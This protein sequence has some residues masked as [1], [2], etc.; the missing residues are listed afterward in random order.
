MSRVTF[1]C[2]P[3]AS[4]LWML[5]LE[6]A[7]VSPA[8]SECSPLVPAWRLPASKS[9]ASKSLVISQLSPTAQRSRQPPSAALM[10]AQSQATF[11]R[12]LTAP[13]SR[14]QTS[15]NA[16]NSLVP[17]T[18][19]ATAR[20]S[21]VRS[22]SGASCL[23]VTKK[24]SNTP[25]QS[26]NS[27]LTMT[28]ATTTTITTATTTTARTP[29]NSM[30]MTMREGVRGIRW[31]NTARMRR[32]EKM[33]TPMML[34]STSKTEKKVR[35]TRRKKSTVSRSRRRRWRMTERNTAGRKRT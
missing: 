12:L 6:V 9:A 29:R 13:I 15:R 27:S 7:A 17:S 33:P 21:R 16:K 34:T 1:K 31:W 23:Q 32:K 30:T 5:C 3:I 4:S 8:T 20:R 11:M 19:S 2:L 24:A 26:A 14:L 22:S 18:F 28:A 25:F 10:A 35:V